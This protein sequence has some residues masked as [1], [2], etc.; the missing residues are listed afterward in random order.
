M[1]KAVRGWLTSTVS[2]LS[3]LLRALLFAQHGC[4]I[5]RCSLFVF[6]HMGYPHGSSTALL[7]PVFQHFQGPIQSAKP[8]TIA[9]E[10]IFFVHSTSI[11]STAKVLPTK[12]SFPPR[13]S[14]RAASEWGCRPVFM[15]VCIV[16]Q[17][18]CCLCL[19]YH[20]QRLAFL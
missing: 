13:L 1:T 14:C 10:A 2:L 8:L 4:E 16:R 20:S 19:W 15:D 9:R 5:H 6:L 7:S 18:C 17:S 11:T 3:L 12:R